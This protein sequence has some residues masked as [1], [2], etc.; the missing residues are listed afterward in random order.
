MQHVAG[1]ERSG[2]FLLTHILA[3]PLIASM[4]D[5]SWAFAAAA[6]GGAAAAAGCPGDALDLLVR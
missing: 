2:P 4:M 3:L 5:T 1:R 6:A